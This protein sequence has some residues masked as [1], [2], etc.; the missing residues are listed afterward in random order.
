MQGD[1]KLRHTTQRLADDLWHYRREIVGLLVGFWGLASLAA[2]FN[3][4]RGSLIGSFSDLLFGACGVG[5]PAAALSLVLAGSLLVARPSYLNWSRL[6][7]Q[8]A[9]L[10]LVWLAC[11]LL[12]EAVASSE[13]ASASYGGLLGWALAGGL[14]RLGG[15]ASL[16]LATFILALQGSQ[17]ALALSWRDILRLAWGALRSTGLALAGLAGWA[18]ARMWRALQAWRRSPRTGPGGMAADEEA[19]GEPAVSSCNEG[20]AVESAD[21]GAVDALSATGERPVLPPITIFDPTPTAEGANAGDERAKA[22]IIEETLAGFGIPAEVVEVQRGPAVTQFG[23]QPGYVDH[24]SGDNAVRRKV[25]VARIRALADDLSLALAASPIRVE[26]P[27]PGRPLVGIEVPNAAVSFVGVRGILESPEYERFK[28]GLR[29]ALGRDISGKPVVVSLERMPHLLIA[30]ATG[31]G[32]SVCIGAMLASLLYAYTPAE[33]RL[34]LIDPKRVELARYGGVPH[35][36]GKPEVE[37]EGAIAAL[38]WACKQMDERYRE[39]ARAG[40]RDIR[41]YNALQEG[42][43]EAASP[44]LPRI[45]IVI[46]EL[47][48]LMLTAPD[49]VE[50]GVCRLAQMARATGIHLIV[51]TQRPSVNVVTGLIKANFPGRISFAVM[52]QIDSRVI[53]DSIGAESLIGQGDMLFLAPDSSRLLRLQGAFA[54][55]GE[56]RRLVDF[57]RRQIVDGQPLPACPWS[58]LLEDEDELLKQAIDVAREVSA[59]S[60]SYLQRR[61]HIGYPRAAHL[62]DLLTNSGVVGPPQGSGRS[63]QVLVSGRDAGAQPQEDVAEGTG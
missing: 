55:E 5:A 36:L 25:R 38:R 31:S 10:L 15:S 22:E 54:S 14:R 62:L 43:G 48:D 29:I 8:A 21:L 16:W 37:V 12:A 60:A 61:L 26:A 18:I 23:V 11:L 20:M 63:R 9:G 35:L 13:S 56:T 53:L 3:L 49:E 7:R 19:A 6:A 24:G 52:S 2:M 42:R 27:I 47:A 57:W 39:F 4:T 30:G 44:L 45:V 17:L 32:K 51:A 1:R 58:G 50:R 40:V 33:L 28:A 59:I 41:S 34:L 46:G